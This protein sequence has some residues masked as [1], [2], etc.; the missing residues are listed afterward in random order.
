MTA[1][2]WRPK[3]YKSKYHNPNDLDIAISTQHTNRKGFSCTI[4]QEN[5][6]N[7]KYSNILKS[8]KT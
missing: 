7:N 1:L 2:N 5:I 6:P 3:Y 8:T 4:F